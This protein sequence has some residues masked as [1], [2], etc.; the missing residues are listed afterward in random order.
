M[1]IRFTVFFSSHVKLGF[2]FF[3][4]KEGRLFLT[5]Q[6]RELLLIKYWNR[7]GW[8]PLVFLCYLMLSLYGYISNSRPGGISG[9]WDKICVRQCSNPISFQSLVHKSFLIALLVSL[10]IFAIRKLK[11]EG[12]KEFLLSGSARSS[13][14]FWIAEACP[15]LEMAFVRAHSH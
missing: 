9:S 5:S 8:W 4:V 12:Q 3:P 14:T 11:D 7:M 15:L 13:G 6:N 10:R 2:F 1:A